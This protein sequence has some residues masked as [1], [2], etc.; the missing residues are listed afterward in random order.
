[1]AKEI[2]HFQAV[3]SNKRKSAIPAALVAGVAILAV[4]ISNRLAVAQNVA[5]NAELSAAEAHR[6]AG[7]NILQQISH[8]SQA[9]YRTLQKSFVT[10][11][12]DPNPPP[13][14]G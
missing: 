2:R 8:E 5:R 4:C 6:A 10:V 3:I 1:M 9:F 7:V 11:E 14:D 13:H 12:M